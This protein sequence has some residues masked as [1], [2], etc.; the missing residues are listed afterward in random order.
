M[1][2]AS[3]AKTATSTS[4]AKPKRAL[5]PAA[6]VEAKRTA[7]VI[8]EV[9]AGARTPMDAAKA[10]AISATRYYILEQRAIEGLIAACE[11]RPKG[12]SASL[13]KEVTKLRQQ[14][15]RLER[16]LLRYQSLARLSHRT[17]GLPAPPSNKAAVSAP[18]K[19]KPRKASVRA[20][21]KAA[22]LQS[23]PGPQEAMPKVTPSAPPVPGL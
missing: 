21:K 22:E 10:L 23:A 1:N 16:D 7:A 4:R 17:V 5:R 11:P 9:L 13:D 18:G 2:S 15:K 20:L 19:R 12:P 14:T 6:S 8:L 3:E